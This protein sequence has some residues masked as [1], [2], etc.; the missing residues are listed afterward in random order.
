VAPLVTKIPVN[1]QAPEHQMRRIR[2]GEQGESLIVT[3]RLGGSVEQLRF[4]PAYAV[5]MVSDIVLNPW[6]ARK[7]IGEMLGGLSARGFDA[8]RLAETS[9]LIVEILRAWLSSERD[10]MAEAHFRAEVAAGRIQF[11]LR[12]DQRNWQMPWV[13]E[14]TEPE[15]ADQL[16]S[17]S[18]GALEKSLFSPIYKN[19]FSNKDERD[20]AVYMDGEKAL[21]WWHRNVARTQYSVQGWRRERIFPDFIFAMRPNLKNKTGRSRLVVLEMKGDYLAGNVDT[22]YKEVLLRLINDAFA[23]QRVSR[24]GELE[25]LIKDGITVECDLV[26]MSDWTTRLPNKYFS[27]DGR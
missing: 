24:V 10:R 8:S 18:G 23:V 9:G 11:R 17:R 3:E 4:D 16:L 6:L 26:L 25:L 13:T 14:T 1:A 22:T 2:L 5:R 12:T 7:I 19:D 20:I 27:G 15:D 21:C